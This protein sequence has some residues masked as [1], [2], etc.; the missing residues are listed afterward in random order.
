MA[1]FHSTFSLSVVFTVADQS[2]NG[3]M[4]TM[5]VYRYNL[6]PGTQQSQI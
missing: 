2:E 3:E 1:T 6:Q 4:R 5:F